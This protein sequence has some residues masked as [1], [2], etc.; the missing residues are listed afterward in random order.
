MP[1]SDTQ[2]NNKDMAELQKKVHKEMGWE[3]GELD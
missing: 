1:W 3:D 2:W